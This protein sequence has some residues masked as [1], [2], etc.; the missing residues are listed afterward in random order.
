M[1]FCNISRAKSRILPLFSTLFGPI[2][3]P[4]LYSFF[5]PYF[6]VRY[7]IWVGD[8]TKEKLLI[9]KKNKLRGDDGY[10]IFSVRIKED[11]VHTL[12]RLSM[13]TNRSR[14]EIINILLDYAIERCEI[15]EQEPD[16][17]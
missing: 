2:Q 12:D 10:K 16:A 14:N 11:T 9:R 15:V 3:Q 5:I 17:K 1:A 6:Y 4:I 13:E 7:T 8:A